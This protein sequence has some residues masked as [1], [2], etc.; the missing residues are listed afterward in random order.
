M[1]EHFISKKKDFYPVSEFFETYLLKYGRIY[2]ESIRYDDLQRYT[3][4]VPVYDENGEDTLWTTVLYSESERK[5]IHRHLL[6][7][8]AILKADGDIS[9]T[10]H[11]FIENVDMCVYGNTLPFRVRVVNGIN[12]NFDYFYVKII[13][14]NRLYGLELEHILS[15]NRI[16]YFIHGETIVEEH[17]IGMPAKTFLEEDMPLTRFDHVRLAKEFVK[18]NERCFVSL[19]GDMHSGNFVIELTRDFEKWHFRIHP[20]DFDQQSHHWRKEVY[21]PQCYQQNV[22]FVE[23]TTKYLAPENVVQYQT[24]ERSLIA[25]RVKVSHGRFNGL[26][27]VMREDIISSDD[28]VRRL[29]AQ[30]AQHYDDAKF[31]HCDTMGELVYRSIMSLLGNAGPATSPL[32]ALKSSSFPDA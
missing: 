7:A 2:P 4:A 1:A 27:S 30:L 28:N 24:E 12:E 29:G 5:E 23:V 18:F 17:T 13:D 3:N 16:N 8:Y 21:L 9:I 26:M 10:R 31:E 19:L 25:N 11:L 15:P 6:K 22:P 32:T 20:I 14:A